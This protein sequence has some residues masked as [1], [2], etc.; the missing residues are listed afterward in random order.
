MLLVD[1]W[2]AVFAGTCT[3]A[4]VCHDVSVAPNKYTVA[5]AP[6]L[7]ETLTHGRPLVPMV[8]VAVEVVAVEAMMVTKES[9]LCESWRCQKIGASRVF[10]RDVVHSTLTQQ[11]L[12]IHT[13]MLIHIIRLMHGALL[14]V[15]QHVQRRLE[16]IDEVFQG[17]TAC[18]WA[19]AE[20]LP[21]VV[22]VLL[23]EHHVTEQ[24]ACMVKYTV[25]LEAAA[26]QANT[27]VKVRALLL[28]P[29]P[30]TT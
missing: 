22:H 10:V 17:L 7:C 21:R 29:T 30:K 12:I 27:H 25:S 8:C 11:L 18:C 6:L 19:Q 28:I 16:V 20:Q 15:V 13:H 23:Q 9:G 24:L 4:A 2:F 5:L 3:P 1:V 26:E 14:Y